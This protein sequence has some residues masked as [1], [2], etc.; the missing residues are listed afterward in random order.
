MG[1]TTPPVTNLADYRKC[2]RC[3]S[4]GKWKRTTAG[5]TERL[6]SRHAR[7]QP[8]FGKTEGWGTPWT[9]C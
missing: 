7:Q 3:V 5:K 4:K 1:K 9:R 8:S 2:D 6:C